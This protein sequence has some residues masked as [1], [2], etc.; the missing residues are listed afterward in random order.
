MDIDCAGDVVAVTGGSKGIGNAIAHRFADSGARVA[1]CAR[2]E[3][4]LEAAAADIEATGA[5]CVPIPADLSTADGADRFVETV[6]DRFGRLDVLVNNAGSAPP[7]RL[8]E[9]TDADWYQGLDLKVMGYVRCTRAAMP[10]LVETG[11]SVVNIT[12]T[13]GSYPNPDLLTSGVTSAA[14]INFTRAVAKEY[15]EDVRVNAVSPGPVETQRWD[16]FIAAMAEEYDLPESEVQRRFEDVFPT[17][18]L[19]TPEDVAAT[20]VFL[21]TPHASFVNGEVVDVDGGKEGA[22]IV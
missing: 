21:T 18:R 8:A 19:C 17:G 5:D 14:A 2:S 4:E 13:G 7:G 12:G 6:L 20:V 1:I 9:L 3:A 16:S 22:W 10:H 11:G 15:G